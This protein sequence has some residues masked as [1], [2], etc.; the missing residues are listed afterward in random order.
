V[1]IIAV[2]C[3]VIVVVAGAG[4]YILGHRGAKK[5]IPPA[6]ANSRGD[7]E[8]T[9]SSTLPPFSVTGSVPANGASTVPSDS[10]ISLSFSAP[11]TLGSVMPSV[12]PALA[13]SW[14]RS[15]NTTLEFDPTAPMIPYTEEVVT[16]LPGSNSIRGP[17]GRSLS[18]PF[19]LKF[20][21][22][23]G[24]TERLQQLLA[25][26]SFLPLAFTASGP[27]PPPN[28]MADPQP[29]SFSWR[30]SA[31]PSSLMSLWTEGSPNEITKGAIMQFESQNGL[32]VDGL[33][34][35]M[36]W[37]TV[38][39]DVASNTADTAPYV[40]VSVSKVLPESLTLYNNGTAQFVGVPVNTGAPGADTA[41]GTFAV[42]EHV[43]SSV[44]KGT[45]PD[46]STY[47]DPNVPWASFFN[48]GDALHGFVRA[49]YGSPQSNGCVEMSVADAALL[50]PLTPIGTLV[51]V[52]G[53]AVT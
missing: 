8:T 6:S 37:L 34:G 13:G 29:G 30:W 11:V 21:V 22:A 19:S 33:A 25:Q 15:S 10:E 23:P 12:T 43:V 49:T 31:L 52:S 2:S 53:P 18:S 51:T 35:P 5:G 9:T 3:M 4:G 32:T 16:V 36:V 27:S 45:N 7:P 14:R 47:D 50:W 17:N 26:L 20:S 24:S 41:D 40:Y 46:G 48:G 44:M 38:L 42:F 39:K 28:Q 1:W